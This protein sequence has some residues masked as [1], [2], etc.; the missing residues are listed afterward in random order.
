M[1]NRQLVTTVTSVPTHQSEGGT[2]PGPKLQLSQSATILAQA[3]LIHM[4]FKIRSISTCTL[5]RIKKLRL[6]LAA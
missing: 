3:S 5:S 6:C 4:K 1:K 2:I